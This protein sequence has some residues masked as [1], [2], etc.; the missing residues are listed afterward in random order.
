MSSMTEKTLGDK[1]LLFSPDTEVLLICRSQTNRIMCTTAIDC[2]WTTGVLDWLWFALHQVRSWWEGW[3]I[4]QDRARIGRETWSSYAYWT[5]SLYTFRPC[6]TIL[7]IP[8][9]KVSSEICSEDQ[10]GVAWEGFVRV[11]V[12]S[13]HLIKTCL[14]S[15]GRQGARKSSVV[16][17]WAF[18]WLLLLPDTCDSGSRKSW[19]H[20]TCMLQDQLSHLTCDTAILKTTP[21]LHKGNW[22]WNCMFKHVEAY[23][24]YI[25]QG[26]AVSIWTKVSHRLS[27]PILPRC[28]RF[29]AAMQWWKNARS[30]LS[31]SFRWFNRW[32]DG[33]V[34]WTA[35]R[36]S[37]F[38]IQVVTSVGPGSDASMLLVT[39]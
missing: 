8:F 5:V 28:I 22:E 31:R 35:H 4:C 39:Y 32:S 30:R 20:G 21:F 1:K 7:H 38:R 18:E 34:C 13:N 17:P 36:S 3:K 15:F 26:G 14:M 33:L 6:Y 37:T 16:E 12:I 9:L 10:V 11:Q 25:R 19:A 23:L 29:R 27:I 2:P 24:S